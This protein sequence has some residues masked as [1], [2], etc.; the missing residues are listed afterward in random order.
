[1]P[2]HLQPHTPVNPEKKKAPPPFF[3]PFG[4]RRPSG[5][6][7]A[8][9]L[10]G[11]VLFHLLFV[12]GIP[13]SLLQLDLEEMERVNEPIDI[14]LEEPPEEEPE[15]R[16]VETNQEAPDNEPDEADTFS[17]RN[18]QAAQEEMPEEL[19]PDH[20]P[21]TEGEDHEAAKPIAGELNPPIT[22]VPAQESPASPEM[23]DPSNPARKDPLPGFEEDEPVDDEG[24]GSSIAEASE[25]PSPVDEQILGEET[26]SDDDRPPVFT[27]PVVPNRAS[28][29]PRPRLPR[30]TPG[31]IRNQPLGVSQVGRIAVDA[32]FSEFGDYLERMIEAVSQRWNAMVASRS[33]GETSVR[34]VLEFKITRDG[35]I[36]DLVVVD[37]TAKALGILLA[38]SAIEQ[39]QPYGVWP[40]EMV[41]VLG[42]SQTITFAFYYW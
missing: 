31:P 14:L 38:R 35:T 13:R 18:Q 25:N 29:A 40:K 26:D 34:V 9:G 11:T 16:F 37:S 23:V 10:I 4:G 12:L 7:I 27:A 1:M 20:T 32:K 2:A 22:A 21:A 19:S 24:A 17:A 36:E 3:S 6:S 42:E 8:V 30:A 5:Q 15:P 28:P 33:Y 41:D 39:G